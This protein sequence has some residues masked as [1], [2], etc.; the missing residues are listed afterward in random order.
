MS[1]CIFCKIVAKQIPAKITHEDAET[2]AFHDINPQAP[3]HLQIIPKKHIARVSELNRET[4]PLM[5]HLVLT[6]NRLAKEF[7][8]SEEGYRLVINCNAAAGQ[9][10]YHLHL[11]LLGGRPMQWPPG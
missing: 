11:H 8:V 10:V 6:A 3:V 4:A 2:V 1:D 9:S 5:A 7:S